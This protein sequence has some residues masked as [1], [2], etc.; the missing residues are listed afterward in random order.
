MLKTIQSLTFI[1]ITLVIAATSC[2]TPAKLDLSNKSDQL[3]SNSFFA[4]DNS[5]IQY[6]GRIDFSNTKAPRFWAPGVYI[7]AKF[8]GSYCSF[9]IKDEMLWGKSHNYLE[10]VID[11]SIK[12]RFQTKTSVDTITIVKNL[13]SGEH[14]ITI[15]K[16]TESGIGYL[17]FIGF[18]TAKLLQLPAKPTR[19][20]EFVG[21]SITCGTGMDLSEFPCDK[22]EWYDQHNAYMSYGPTTARTLNAQWHLTAVSGIGLMH[23][24]CNM[25]ET[26]PQVFDKVSVRESTLKWDFSKY[27]P[28]AITL[29]LGQNDGVQD[30]TKFAEEYVK[31]I[32]TVRGHYP[33]TQII[34]ITSPMADAKLRATMERNITGIV[35]EMRRKGDSNVDRFFFS[36]GFN[37]GCGGHPDLTDHQLIAAELSAYLKTKLNW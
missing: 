26:M 16:N 17:E 19:R 6:T 33:Q 13:S 4:A 36:R 22:R 8:S 5:L 15:C 21:N 27:Q 3:L 28:D 10:V 9:I 23:S 18:K 31:F 24:C 29:C 1:A 2:K 34:L 32:A 12:Y 37:K 14:T 35:N 30:S 20:L 7:K 25:T 11:D